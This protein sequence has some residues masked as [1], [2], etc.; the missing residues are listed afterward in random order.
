MANDYT[1]LCVVLFPSAAWFT[2]FTHAL[3]D[4]SSDKLFVYFNTTKSKWSSWSLTDFLFN[5]ERTSLNGRILC[6]LNGFLVLSLKG[7]IANLHGRSF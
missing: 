4:N 5:V 7:S 1:Y 6:M 3:C 2:W